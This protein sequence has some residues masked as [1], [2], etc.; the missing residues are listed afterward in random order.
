MRAAQAPLDLYVEAFAVAKI[1]FPFT[2]QQ[3]VLLSDGT[4]DCLENTYTF[5]G[6]YTDLAAH[7]GVMCA[8][9][10]DGDLECQAPN[11]VP[12]YLQSWMIESINQINVG[13][14]L[15]SI[16]GNYYFWWLTVNAAAVCIRPLNQIG[17]IVPGLE[18]SERLHTTGKGSEPTQSQASIYSQELLELQWSR[19]PSTVLGYEIRRDGQY[20]G[21]TTDV[22]FLDRTI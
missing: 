4:I 5:N 14:P 16:E 3:C 6:L 2:L 12:D 9:D 11:I 20:M 18:S 13:D 21:Y 10:L 22:S 19:V 17:L 15:V 1:G 7:Y 8:L